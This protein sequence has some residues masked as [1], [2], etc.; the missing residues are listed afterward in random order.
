MTPTTSSADFN[1]PWALPSPMSC[2]SVQ[3]YDTSSTVLSPHSVHT[4]NDGMESDTDC[5]P[6][7]AFSGFGSQQS[8]RGTHNSSDAVIN[9]HN[10]HQRIHT[11]PPSSDKQLLL[12]VYGK[13]KVTLCIFSVGIIASSLSR[14]MFC[15][16]TKTPCCLFRYRV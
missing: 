1:Q 14:I 13:L 4:Y 9:L 2:Q 5:G 10:A 11:L 3:S 7:P 12:E 8:L 16:Y 6:S 15:A